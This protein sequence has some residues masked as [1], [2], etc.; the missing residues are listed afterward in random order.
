M[1]MISDLKT[2]YHQLVFKRPSGTSRGVL[3]TKDSWIIYQSDSDGVRAIS[4]VSIIEGLSVESSSDVEQEL[5]HILR[6]P[7]QNS[8]SK[9]SSVR[10]AQE[11]LAKSQQGDDPYG[12]WNCGFHADQEPIKINGLIW[13]GDRQFMFDQI[14]QKLDEGFDCLKLKIGAIDFN[15]ELELLAYVRSQFSSDQVELRVDANGAFDPGDALDKLKRLSEYDLHS[16]EQPIKHGQSQAMSQLCAKSPIAIALD[17]ELIGYSYD[18]AQQMKLLQE[19][20]PQYIILKPSLIGGFGQADQWIA[21][22]ES[23]DIGWWATSALEANIGLN[24]IAQWVSTKS[25]EMPQGLGTGQLY[26][27]NISSP[28]TITDG[29]LLYHLNKSW[30][31]A[32]FFNEG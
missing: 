19:I 27:N 22:A 11:L 28:L 14:K 12:L 17:E 16:I 24:A 21:L 3:K 1:T 8:L 25:N 13:M 6:S 5:D 15:D 2:K 4:E 18:T 23:L 20:K 32:S 26:T 30:D 10:F 9:I 7:D 29:H 31:V